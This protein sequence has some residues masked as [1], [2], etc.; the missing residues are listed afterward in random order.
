MIQPGAVFRVPPELADPPGRAVQDDPPLRESRWVLVVS[1]KTD[2]RD[3]L[4]GT[5]NT[6]LFSAQTHY[7]GRHDVLVQRP[8]GG[9]E[10]DS[11][12]QTDLIFTIAKY[13]LTDDRHRGGTGSRIMCSIP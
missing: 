9:L 10:R 13:E 2:C 7:A 12:A 4:H 5:V 11:I 3:R 6:V 8:D 1:N